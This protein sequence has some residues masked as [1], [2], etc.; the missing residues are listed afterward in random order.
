[1]DLVLKILRDACW[2]CHI[3]GN[4]SLEVYTGNEAITLMGSF[5]KELGISNLNMLA[6]CDNMIRN[7]F[8]CGELA[9]GR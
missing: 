1:V 8:H 2:L 5:E 7:Y 6:L 9:E 4:T 3:I